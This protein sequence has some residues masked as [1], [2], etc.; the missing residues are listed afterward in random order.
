MRV[1]WGMDYYRVKTCQR[2]PQRE[3]ERRQVVRVY[4]GKSNCDFK[5]HNDT[6]II[7]IIIHKTS[8]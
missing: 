7:I 6:V 8:E 3:E 4:T 2:R 1:G 5:G